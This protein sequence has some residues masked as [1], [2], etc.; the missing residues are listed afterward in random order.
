MLNQYRVFTKKN[1]VKK[2]NNLWDK[3]K[4]RSDVYTFVDFEYINI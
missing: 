4:I 1:S 2:F 3:N